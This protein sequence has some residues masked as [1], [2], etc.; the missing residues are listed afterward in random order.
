MARLRQILRTRLGRNQRLDRAGAI[1][2]ADARR[3]PARG[4][5]RDREVGA[6]DL[7]VVGDHPLQAQLARPLLGKRHAD[8][9]APVLGHEN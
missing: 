6:V 8:Q 9:A 3:D 5:H 7:A 1:T 2:R 4:I